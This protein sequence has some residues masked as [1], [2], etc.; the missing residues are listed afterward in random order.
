M[1][2]FTV[3]VSFLSGI[4]HIH[5]AC[6]EFCPTLCE[7]KLLLR[8]FIFSV[9]ILWQSP[10]KHDTSLHYVHK[11]IKSCQRSEHLPLCLTCTRAT[12]W[13]NQQNDMCAQQRLR[14]GGCSLGIRPVWSESSLCALR[15]AQEGPNAS[16]CGQ[17]RPWL[18]WAN[19]QADLSLRWAHRSFCWFCHAA[20]H[21]YNN[22]L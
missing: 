7:I 4:Y 6:F 18:E 10:G 5:N 17:R 19:A 20:A 14:S 11:C 21:M 22:T 12:A 2:S 15:I 3:S 1:I 9:V 16:L 8:I 13:Q